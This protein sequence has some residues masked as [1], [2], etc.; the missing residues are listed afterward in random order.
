MCNQKSV[1]V[2][3]KYLLEN[4]TRRRSGICN[5]R[6]K[7]L[8]RARRVGTTLGPTF[9]SAKIGLWVRASESLSTT[10]GGRGSGFPPFSFIGPGS[11]KGKGGEHAAS[12]ITQTTLAQVSRR[13]WL[14]LGIQALGVPR[15]A[16]LPSAAPIAQHGEKGHAHT[17][18]LHRSEAAEGPSL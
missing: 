8:W 14:R 7:P 17:N 11:D 9:P 3:P 15:R 18:G 1:V 4:T 10:L 16:S 2:P 5:G 6:F 13:A 12:S